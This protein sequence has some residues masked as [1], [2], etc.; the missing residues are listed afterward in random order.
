MA[1]N[2]FSLLL[3]IQKLSSFYSQIKFFFKDTFNFHT[4]VAYVKELSL[5]QKGGKTDIYNIQNHGFI[6]TPLSH[7]E[8]NMDAPMKLTIFRLAV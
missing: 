4:L 5:G 8:R 1:Y 6:G 2:R 7:I 3:F